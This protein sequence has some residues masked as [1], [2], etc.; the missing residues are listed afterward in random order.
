MWNKRSLVLMAMIAILSISLLNAIAQSES[1][2][3]YNGVALVRGE[4][5]SPLQ[6]LEANEYRVSILAKVSEEGLFPLMRSNS[7]YNYVLING[8]NATFTLNMNSTILRPTQEANP[9]EGI[10]LLGP[11]L[12]RIS[13]DVIS[14]ISTL[15][16][17]A[18]EVKLVEAKVGEQASANISGQ[19]LTGQWVEGLDG[20]IFSLNWSREGDLSDVIICRNNTLFTFVG[21]IK[22]FAKEVRLES[23]L[24]QYKYSDFRLEEG[25]VHLMAY[26]PTMSLTLTRT[27][28]IGKFMGILITSDARYIVRVS[29]LGHTTYTVL[30]PQKCDTCTIGNI[31][32]LLDPESRLDIGI[33][34]PDEATGGTSVNILIDPGSS[35]NLTIYLPGG[36]SI[37]LENRG[38]KYD[39][40]VDLPLTTHDALENIYVTGY[41]NSSIFGI[42]RGI[43]ILRSYDIRLLNKTKIYLIGGRGDLHIAALNMGRNPLSLIEARL[44]LTTSREGSIS[45]KFPLSMELKANESQRIFLPLSLRTGDYKGSLYVLVKDNSGIHEV[46]L[47]EVSIVSTSEDPL[48]VFVAISPDFP[49]VG[50]EINLKISFSSM[51]PLSKVLVIV[52]TSGELRPESDTSKLLKNIPEG[53]SKELSFSFR[54]LKV[55]PA[56]LK[57]NVYYSILGEGSERVITKDLRLPI[58][59]VTGRAYVSVEKSD[60]VVSEKL[61]IRIKVDDVAG[62]VLVEF[63]K[64][65]S[66]LEAEGR[67]KENAVEFNAPGEIEVI[68]SFTDDGNYTIPTY[69]SVN[70]SLLV[71]SNKVVVRVSKRGVE[72]KEASLRSKLADLRRRFKTLKETLKE[73]QMREKLDKIGGMLKEAENLI[74]RSDYGEADDLLDKAEALI[75]SLEEYTY[76]SLDDLM[77]GLTYFLIGV[78]ITSAILLVLRLGRSFKK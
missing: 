49:K 24:I 42:K 2:V 69:V 34:A 18:T 14:S 23:P 68:G 55:G 74:N 28:P 3:R 48:N 73:P 72:S 12:L 21:L 36:R 30:S 29:E 31:T 7:T 75:S 27:I 50:D 32:Y 9:K 43:R 19:S 47:G 38:F 10:A 51:V 40:K 57:A 45:L 33:N 54:A 11:Y 16:H 77:K 20:W 62:K 61:P 22:P 56:S 44:N 25:I 26:G 46:T 15:S 52:N 60:V 13:G 53:S 5:S 4:G 65:M 70:G 17:R 78:G 67:I 59:G 1:V 6:L 64:E 8:M 66:I 37:L 41:L 63:P 35:S 39:L 71:P 76:S 58:G